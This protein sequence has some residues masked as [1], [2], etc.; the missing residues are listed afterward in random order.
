MALPGNDFWLFDDEL[1]IFNHF[2]GIGNWAPPGEEIRTEPEVLKLC[3][4]AFEAV[5]ERAVPHDQYH[6]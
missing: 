5:W 2:D 3:G 4:N 1:A 6:V